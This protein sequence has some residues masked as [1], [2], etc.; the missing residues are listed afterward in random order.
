M[1]SWVESA[2]AFSTQLYDCGI[3]GVYGAAPPDNA[4]ALTSMLW[5]A[6]RARVR[7]WDGPAERAGGP[8]PPAGHGA[9]TSPLPRPAS[10]LPPPRL[11]PASALPPP[12]RSPATI[13]RTRSANH[14]LRLCTQRVAPEE[15]TRGANQ[16][17]SSVLM[18]LETRGLLVEDIGR[19]IL[20]HGKRLDP[21]TLVQRIRAVTQEDIVRVMRQALGAPP[22]F[23]AV[24]DV[25][26]IAP[27][28]AIREH[29]ERGAQQ[30][31]LAPGST[32]EGA[33]VAGAP[34]RAAS[35]S[36][37]AGSAAGKAAAAA[38]QQQQ[39][40]QQQQAAAS[41]TR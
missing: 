24:G 31:R 39:Q 38:A 2:N 41:T 23:A 16:L 12:A 4:G 10:A 15:L 35:A 1:H 40:Q 37:S 25:G 13:A 3:V 26:A 18:N 32:F 22:A 11:R 36:A 14:L 7:P 19:Q 30:W 33:R 28:E 34:R 8:A 6:Q 29:L 17:A 5:V 9:L 20:S 21:A 27:Y